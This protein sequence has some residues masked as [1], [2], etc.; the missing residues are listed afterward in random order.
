M[1]PDPEPSPIRTTGKSRGLSLRMRVVLLTATIN[2]LVFVAGGLWLGKGF[3]EIQGETSRRLF[4]QLMFSIAGNIEAGDDLDVRAILLDPQWKLVADAMIVSDNLEEVRGEVLT[5]G[6]AINPLG[7]A[8]RSG[9]GDQEILRAM[10]E[11]TRTGQKVEAAGGWVVLI[12]DKR[13]TWGAFWYRLPEVLVDNSAIEM[14]LIGWLL[15]STVLLTGG[16]F[17]ALSSLVLRPVDRLAQAV[18]RMEGGDLTS[19]VAL[20]GGSAELSEL[21]HGFNARLADEVRVA[22]SAARTAE[23]AAMTQR[24]LA[25][26]GEFA[27]GIAHEIN[28]PLGGLLNAV[29]VIGKPETP[30]EKH[31]RYVAL[32]QGGLER[33]RDTVGQ[34][35]RFTPRETTA[36]QV[37]LAEVALDSIALVNHR[38]SGLGID[39]AFL[40]DSVQIEPSQTSPIM[41]RVVVFGARNEL[42][43]AMLNLLGNAI[44][45]L[46]E[47]QGNGDRGSANDRIELRLSLSGE[48]APTVVVSDNGPGVTREQVERVADM[49]FTTKE[50]GRG[51]GLGLSIVHSIVAAHE[52]RVFIESEP[53]QGF[54]VRL[55]FPSAEGHAA[56]LQARD[57][58]GQGAAVFRPSHGP[59]PVEADEREPG[60]A[61]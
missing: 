48:S 17:I 52:G 45:A 23:Q 10:L 4:D 21:S 38:A 36:V 26:M 53:G 55:E 14:T 42:G 56:N 3:G 60:D 37:D 54:H 15:V 50:V 20:A 46:E 28:N 47:A 1:D 59:K 2:V 49:F 9:D 16:T 39:V 57:T 51:T 25:A 13:D 31:S 22:T 12:E 6:V 11:A 35:L 19:R 58:D 33:I 18:R 34:L 5:H 30:P 7:R 40:M 41:G 44:D 24:R 61:S 32:V 29:E 27:A 43:Q 8:A